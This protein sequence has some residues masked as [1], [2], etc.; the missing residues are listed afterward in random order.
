MTW[1]PAKYLQ[2]QTERFAPFEDLLALVPVRPRLRV[3][4][5]GCGT[6]QLT[7]RLAAALPESEVLG[8]DFS[9]EMLE[10]AAG[11]ARPGLSFR[12]GRIET[13]E[14]EWDVVFSNAAIHWVEDHERLVP[15]LFSLLAPGGRLAVQLPANH[16]AP[17]HQVI[18]ETARE[19]PFATALGG[20]ARAW[21]G[22]PATRYAE[23]L[24]DAGASEIVA[25]DKVYPH[26]L[27]NAS[28]VVD[29][30]SG[31]ALVPYFERLPNELHEPFQERCR[32]KLSRLMP[33][34][35]V[36]FPF[37]RT[38]FAGTRQG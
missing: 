16:E 33:G 30:I 29:W 31:T 24:F 1:D 37:K 10:R 25:F 5:L 7:A 23:L 36:F 21:Q 27:Q 18:R 17:S 26:V 15:R 2:F 13:V 9:A 19:E 35:P 34:S 28:A 8:I 12:Q 14:G 4:D 11:L 3:I 22:L 32:E 6:G 38:L 20:W